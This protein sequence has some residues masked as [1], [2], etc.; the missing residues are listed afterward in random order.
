MNNDVILLPFQGYKIKIIKSY[1]HVRLLCAF[2][3]LLSYLN[4]QHHKDSD[5]ASMAAVVPVFFFKIHFRSS[6]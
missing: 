3:E 4:I 5:L 1:V 6:N 2:K